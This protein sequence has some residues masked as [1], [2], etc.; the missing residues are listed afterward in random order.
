MLKA[1]GRPSS[2]AMPFCHPILVI[3][4]DHLSPP[5]ATARSPE[6]QNDATC[7]VTPQPTG[8]SN[9]GSQYQRGS[10]IMRRHPGGE[11]NFDSAS[12]PQQKQKYLRNSRSGAVALLQSCRMELARRPYL[13][14][15]D[16][17]SYRTY[18]AI[19]HP[20]FLGTALGRSASGP[21]SPLL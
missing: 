2:R 16:W 6:L 1:P 10:L 4:V 21:A 17:S 12:H 14:R 19:Y 18:I 9:I 7:R 13:M 20:R 5:P 15:S 3:P 11:K 8:S